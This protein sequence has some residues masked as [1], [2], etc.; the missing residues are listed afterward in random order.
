MGVLAHLSIIDYQGQHHQYYH[1][2]DGHPLDSNGIISN[3]PR[4]DHDFCVET[5]VRRL[6][7]IKSEYNYFIDI[8]YILD[9]KSRMIEISSECYTEANFKGTFEEAIRHF[10]DADYSE[11]NALDEFPNITDL[12]AIL[13]HRLIDGV[14]NIIRAVVANVPH[15]KYDIHTHRL[16]YVGDNTIF[17]TFN[18]F[19]E[20]PECEMNEN[21]HAIE[22]AYL[23]ARRIGA[24]MYFTNTITGQPFTLFYML[25]LYRD[26]Y[27][28]P[29]TEKFIRY[30]EIPDECTKLLELAM[31]VKMINIR[32]PKHL[33]AQN[34]LYGIHSK[35]ELQ[36]IRKSL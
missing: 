12:S 23:N 21:F 14:W 1:F 27:I 25:R 11:K 33:R 15:L 3:F 8:Y 13:N 6:R 26:G 19:I 4:G 22:D 17:Y 24:K 7:L 5:F 31:L 16:V 34:F 10:D 35:K 2:G 18:D 28:L 32:D 36:E 9:L 20:F 30:G 29:L